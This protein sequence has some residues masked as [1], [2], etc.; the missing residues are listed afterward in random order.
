MPNLYVA[1]H[2]LI[3]HK[4]SMLRNKETGNKD[5]RELAS[6]ITMLL[7]YEATRDLKMQKVSFDT[8][9][10]SSE[11]DMLENSKF[12]IV[13]VLRAGIGMV[14]AMLSLIPKA[15][16]GML[17]FCRNEETL[18]ADEYYK[19]F[20]KTIAE[21]EV[22]LVDPMLATGGTAIHSVSHLK[23]LGCKEIKFICLL[24]SPEGVEN[25]HKV[26]GDVSV[27][28]GALDRGLNENGYIV[29][30]LGDAGDRIFGTDD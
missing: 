25:F 2:A 24:A 7:C 12:T 18:V 11:F 23:K 10:E 30:G 26:H 28:T 21:S 16:I 15:K 8:P 29:P 1:N 14:D 20:P 27:Y 5:F 4:L 17:G 13:P 19:N 22:F 6:E 3:T 9:V